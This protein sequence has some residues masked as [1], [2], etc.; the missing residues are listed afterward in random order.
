MMSA[1][2]CTAFPPLQPQ[3]HFLTLHHL[4]HLAGF[5]VQQ[6]QIQKAERSSFPRECWTIVFASLEGTSWEWP[7]D[8]AI[9]IVLGLRRNT[10]ACGLPQLHCPFGL[11]E[12]HSG[13]KPPCLQSLEELSGRSMRPPVRGQPMSQTWLWGHPFPLMPQR[14]IISSLDT[15]GGSN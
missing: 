15:G 6:L 3:P 11:T 1:G 12:F 7:R 9:R 14:S 4:M 8:Q 5:W 10:S 13:V 2:R